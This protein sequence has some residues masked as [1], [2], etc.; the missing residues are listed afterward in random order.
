VQV[1]A[2]FCQKAQGAVE[3]IDWRD[4]MVGASPSHPYTLS[5]FHFASSSSSDCLPI[6]TPLVSST[7]HPPPSSS[8]DCLPIVY[9]VRY[10]MVTG[11]TPLADFPGLRE[12]REVKLFGML[13]NILKLFDEVGLIILTGCP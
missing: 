2:S 12:E 4:T 5:I 10:T 3:E 1:K 13:A 11:K 6:V 9:P 7:S 8:S